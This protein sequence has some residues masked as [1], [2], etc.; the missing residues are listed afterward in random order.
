MQSVT[1]SS[2]IPPFGGASAP[3]SSTLFGHERYYHANPYPA[4]AYHP[5]FGRAPS[6]S[7]SQRFQMGIKNVLNG[8][9]LR[10]SFFRSL[11]LFLVT[12]PTAAIIPG[13]QIAVI[14]AAMG[15]GAGI[16]FFKGFKNP[17]KVAQQ[18]SK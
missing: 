1:G 2:N 5:G 11:L 16:R 15:I 17:E 6:N 12:L 13:P 4:D 18:L 3:K 7:I 9:N 8:S 10:K 14:P